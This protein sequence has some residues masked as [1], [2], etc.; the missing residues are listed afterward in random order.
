MARAA[1]LPQSPAK[2]QARTVPRAA[3]KT[4]AA[5]TAKAKASADA[6]KKTA[7][8]SSRAN[9]DSDDTDDEL[10][11]LTKQSAPK[12]RARTT[13]TARTTTKAATSTAA[14][15]SK[16]SATAS[17]KP[18]ETEEDQAAK[19]EPKKRPGRPKK[20]TPP[21]ETPAATAPKARGRPKGSTNKTSHASSKVS[22]TTRKNTRTVPEPEPA[23]DSSEP[24]QIVISTK[25]T[26][27]R[28]N[29]LRG[30]A[31]KKTVTFQDMM[32]SGSE[33]EE[34]IL[35]DVPAQAKAGSKTAGKSG[36][37]ATPV[38]K[39]G[40]VR[41]RKLAAK[42]ASQ[43]LFPKKAKQMAKSLSAYTSSDGEEDELIAAKEDVNSPARLVVHSPVKEAAENPGLG[44]PVRK[45]NFTPKKPSTMVDENGEPKLSTPKHGTTGLSSPVRKINFTPKRSQAAHGNDDFLKLS[46]GKNVDF[47]DSIF[48][49]SP[50]RRPELS[51][52]KFSHADTPN[53]HLSQS[54]PA[55]NFTPGQASP[56][57]MS[58][59]KGHLSASLIQSPAKSTPA[60]PARSSLFLSP[61]K[62]GV[63]P[64]KSSLFKP[65]SPTRTEAPSNDE[66]STTPASLPAESPVASKS[67]DDERDG[68]INMVEEV[69]RDLFGVELQSY[70][71]LSESPPPEQPMDIEELQEM[72]E[73]IHKSEDMPSGIDLNMDNIEAG[74]FQMS[75]VTEVPEKEHMRT[76][77]PT[78]DQNAANLDLGDASDIDIDGQLEALQKEIQSEPD[79]FGTVCFNTIESLQAPFKEFA[80]QENL[81]DELASEDVV[82]PRDQRSDAR[83]VDTQGLN[84]PS[85]D[86]TLNFDT[87]EQLQAS[88]ESDS[89]QGELEDQEKEH[90]ACSFDQSDDEHETEMEEDEPTMVPAEVTLSIMFNPGLSE[91]VGGCEQRTNPFERMPSIPPPA[92]TPPAERA[93]PSVVD[94]VE[95]H[96]KLYD[97]NLEPREDAE[98][99]FFET[100]QSDFPTPRVPSAADTPASAGRRK[101]NFNVDLGFTP[102]AQKFGHWETDASS[103]NLSGK[104]RR[105]GVFSL[106]GPLE[107]H[108]EP[109]T[110][111]IGDVSYPDLSR[112][113]LANTPSLFAELPLQGR[114][115]DQ[116]MSPV[117]V[118]TAKSPSATEHSEVMDSP[119]RSEIFE[120]PDHIA[121]EEEHEQIRS[122]Q[123]SSTPEPIERP[124]QEMVS[125]DEKENGDASIIPATPIRAAPEH[126]TFHTVSKVP[127][128]G[129]G[130]ISP[131]KVPRKRGHSL[132]GA[133]PTRS[134]P[135]V[136]KPAFRPFVDSA[137]TLSP[138]RKSP[139]PDR[140]P[141]PKRRCSAPRRSLDAPKSPSPVRSP[142]KSPRKAKPISQALQGAVVHVDVHTT[143]GEDASGIFVELLQQMGAR[144][145]M[146]WS[147]NGRSS[148]SPVDGADPKDS[149]VGITHVVYKDGGLRTLEK[150]KQASGLVKCVGVGW[151]LDCER[152]NKWLDETP[153]TFDSSIVPRGGAKRRKSMEPRALS[154]V[155]G[156]VVQV[157]EPSTPSASGRRCGANSGAIEGFRKITPPTPTRQEAPTTPTHQSSGDYNFPQ[158]PGYNFANLDAIGMSPA[159]PYFLS[160][161][162]QLVQQSC[163]PKQSNKGLFPVSKPTFSLEEESEEESRR[164][165]RAR[166]EAA[167][168][169]SLF[170]RPAVGS[171]LGK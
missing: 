76:D 111:D 159:T 35:A 58:P 2:R 5:S 168:R 160:S 145:V 149:R 75:D 57:K 104:P 125:D 165:Q 105:R 9:Y 170:Y 42:D 114:T 113:P 126:R 39:A 120:D 96:N 134:S 32:D 10:D 21:A 102:L 23:S 27:M 65:K 72:A 80:Q 79:D 84:L 154:N 41:G 74:P 38:R 140:S 156:S 53:H 81:G 92:L 70:Q 4:T 19:P 115:D 15:R 89:D 124:E 166:M 152:E 146:S 22:T 107:K 123:V 87:L 28:S 66:V 3:M 158:T 24:K 135:R 49:S 155:N 8:K 147:W 71:P 64:F 133:S 143:E 59:R 148:L 54:V 103:Q 77:E 55:P 13:P 11:I 130:E 14:A 128:K 56:L 78:E 43:P 86:H 116:S 119:S 17:A 18:V 97:I 164:Q 88:I 6:R 171:P 131:L 52:F 60:F 29:I 90:D 45:I 163:P 142:S 46:A 157:A 118:G 127:L 167:R 62:K 40:V 63:S 12:P 129:E 85:S 25:S 83:G 95:S 82:P 136:R 31:K 132:S 33:E 94:S 117:H 138:T 162:N 137:P 108:V 69:A 30:P 150:V 44:S 110:P 109:S 144:C 91:E 1:V 122:R 51:P 48:L 99:S 141:T 26:T 139:R 68:D 47:N 100:T 20:I 153:Y 7:A 36:L 73:K 161:R 93:T 151:V 67:F 112:T 61:A 34:E 106:V 101:S 98:D 37:G 50:A 169:K 121:L 16:K